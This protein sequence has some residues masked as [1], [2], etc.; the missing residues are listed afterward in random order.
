MSAP[1]LTPTGGAFARLER[2]VFELAP[3]R[4]RL[5]LRYHLMRLRRR[6]EPELAE[7][8]RM[9]PRGRRAIDIGANHGVYSYALARVCSHVEAFEPQ[10]ACAETLEAWHHPNVHVHVA[11]LSDRAG[12]LELYVPRAGGVLATG[13]ASFDKPDGDVERITVPVHRLDDFDFRDVAF[14][15]IDVEG[16]EASVV[17]GA[18]ETL[19][20]ERPR[21]LVEIEQRHLAGRSIDEV[22]AQIQALGYDGSFLDGA[23]W[24]P[25]A[26]FSVDRHQRAFIAGDAQ[27]P[28]VNNFVFA[29]R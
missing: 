28:Y 22:F 14:I 8:I 4:L 27:A 2:R 24:R 5:P 29:A 7:V 15:K 25:L 16:H 6:L 11:G 9:L 20:R 13:Y 26:E 17:A 18:T 12:S 3:R 1:K 23:R 19:R 10:R 21:L